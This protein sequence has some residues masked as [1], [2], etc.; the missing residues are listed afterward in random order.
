MSSD[1]PRINPAHSG[2]PQNASPTFCVLTVRNLAEPIFLLASSSSNHKARELESQKPD[3]QWIALHPS[4][5]QGKRKLGSDWPERGERGLTAA[6]GGGVC[7]WCGH[8]LG[9]HTTAWARTSLLHLGL[10]MEA[11]HPGDVAPWGPRYLCLRSSEEALGGLAHTTDKAC[12][13]RA[14]VLGP[15]R[16][17]PQTAVQTGAAPVRATEQHQGRAHVYVPSGVQPES[18]RAAGRWWPGG[19]GRDWREGGTNSAPKPSTGLLPVTAAAT[20]E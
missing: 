20:P 4:D 5:P 16:E 2:L 12:Q 10:T 9:T 1:L 14:P 6:G 13:L 11:Q 17:M 19:Q 7:G 15:P 3:R 18:S 8:L